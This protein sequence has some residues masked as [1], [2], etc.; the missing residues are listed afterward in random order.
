MASKQLYYDQKI[1]GSW[2]TKNIIFIIVARQREGEEIQGK[3]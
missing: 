1:F 3:T 2:V